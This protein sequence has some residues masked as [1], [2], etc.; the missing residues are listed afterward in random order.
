MAKSL[1]FF[2]DFDGTISKEDVCAAMVKKFAAPGW[3]EL[4][5]LWEAG[6]LSTRECAQR[7]LDLM[8]MTPIDSDA[9][10]REQEIDPTFINFA[11][12]AREQGH[13]LYILSDGYA[14]HIGPI[15][16]KYQLQI[17]FYA[18]QMHYR[19]GWQIETPH[20]NPRCGRCGVCKS[21][22]MLDLMDPGGTNIYIGDGYSDRCP[23]HFANLVFAKESLAAYC[24]R[25][26]IAAHYYNNFQDVLRHVGIS[27]I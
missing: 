20:D 21:K 12:W 13:P 25:E 15:L 3:Q 8:H 1:I 14:N 26:G 24:A 19:Q 5:Q 11:V 6:K 2:V 23:A 27:R 16:E 7:T 18:N 17:P 10:T 9:F 22:I 4:N